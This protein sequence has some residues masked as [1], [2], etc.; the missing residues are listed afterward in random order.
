MLSDITESCQFL[1]ESYPGAGEAVEYLN[2]RLSKQSQQK[3]Q[4]G[5]FPDI[6]NIN[7]LVSIVGE[8]LLKEAKLFYSK[9]IE[10]SLYPR[11][12]QF[13]YFNDYQLILPFKDSYGKIVALVGRS[14][15]KD[16]ERK[17]ESISKY[18]N[19]IFTKGNYLF[20]LYENKE[21]ILKENHVYIV[22]GQFDVIKAYEKGM[23]NVVALGSSN[24]SL[25][26]FSL[27]TRYTNNLI[28]LLDND[29]AGEKGRKRIM[30][31]FRNWADIHNFYLPEEYKDI[32]EWFSA[33][34][35]VDIPFVVKN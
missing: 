7:S 22:E 34:D 24:M 2:S 20:G 12:I 35:S 8:P 4:F 11:T 16:E 30:D 31:K 5:Y 13:S 32:D 26:Q 10:D 9:E 21:S 27:I 29:E 23:R 1:L 14:L 25:I 17:K 18:K 19:T 33:N 28:L 15:L 3:F 6:E